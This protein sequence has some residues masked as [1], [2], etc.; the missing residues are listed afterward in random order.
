MT[1]KDL[2]IE[3]I[4]GGYLVSADQQRVAYRAEGPELLDW[5]V[6]VYGDADANRRW[7]GPRLCEACL[8]RQAAKAAKEAEA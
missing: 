5:L 1:P 8:A 3:A 6:E 4:D 7:H 2:R